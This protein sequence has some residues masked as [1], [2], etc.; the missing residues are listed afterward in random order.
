MGPSSFAPAP[1]H[2]PRATPAP[3]ASAPFPLSRTP[4]LV[5]FLAPFLAPFPK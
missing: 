4:F 3:R 1:T 5:P 2:I